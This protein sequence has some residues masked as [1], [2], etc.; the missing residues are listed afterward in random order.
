MIKYYLIVFCCFSRVMK[1]TSGSTVGSVLFTTTLYQAPSSVILDNAGV[2]YAGTFSGVYKWLPA[3]SGY[4]QIITSIYSGVN[5]IRF[6]SFG[7]LYT[8]GSYLSNINR[9][10]ITANYC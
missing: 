3:S 6:D 9:Y 5:R 1:F 10:N 2:V 7:N 4:V 8:A